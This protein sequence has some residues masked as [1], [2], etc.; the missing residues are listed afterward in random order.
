MFQIV[1]L[2]SLEHDNISKFYGTSLQD[3][4]RCFITGFCT[5]SP[6]QFKYIS[7]TAMICFFSP[8]VCYQFICPWLHSCATSWTWDWAKHSLGTTNSWRCCHDEFVTFSVDLCYQ[9]CRDVLP[10]S[11][12]DCSQGP[13]TQQW[14]QPAV[15]VN[16]PLMCNRVHLFG[17]SAAYWGI[18]SRGTIM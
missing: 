8:R 12:E 11:A 14:Y 13:K 2:G 1:Q 16:L 7:C 9:F 17:C 5:Y 10:P 15:Y 18:E 6:T 3:Q 4:N